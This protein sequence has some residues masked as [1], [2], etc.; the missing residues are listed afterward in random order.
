MEVMDK[1]SRVKINF[2]QKPYDSPER[3]WKFYGN[4]GDFLELL[5][6][7][8]QWYEYPKHFFV[9]DFPLHV[10]IEVTSNCNM[11]CPMCYRSQLRDLGD[12]DWD[13]FKKIVDEC[14]DNGVYSVRLSWRGEPLIHPRI[15]DMV[16]YATAWIPNV[17]FLTNV[18][19]VTR[20]VADFLIESE[21][22]YLA[23]SFDGIGEIY[24]L[25][26]RPAKYED[27]LAKLRY[28]KE[29]R[30]RLNMKKPQIRVTTIWPAISND[31]QAYY[32]ALK[33]VTD[34][35]VVNEY[36]DFSAPY[37]PIPDFI[38]QY[39]WERLIVAHD[40]R[41]QRCVGINSNDLTLGYIQDGS[42]RDFWHSTKLNRFRQLHSQTRRLDSKGCKA[43]RHRSKKTDQSVDIYEIIQRDH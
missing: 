27:S 18:F 26:R 15:F 38:C 13:V 24:E 22:T 35:I 36:K 17:S 33:P 11:N 32:D 1:N 29:T 10:D 2:N 42:L 8:L 12:M 34:M 6:N 5:I 21:L 7:R 20:K 4:Q 28:L 16:K 23:C 39:P 9:S 3:Y 41:V 31:P 37:D 19:F 14:E 43:C 30:D 25:I 40:G